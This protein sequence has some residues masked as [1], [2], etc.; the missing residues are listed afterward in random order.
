MLCSDRAK[1]TIE[2]AAVTA[3]TIVIT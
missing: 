3:S 1:Q 2:T